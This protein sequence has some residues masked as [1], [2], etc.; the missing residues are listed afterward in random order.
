MIR[1]LVAALATLL[2]AGTA[3]ASG[4]YNLGAGVN[5]PAADVRSV[6]VKTTNGQVETRQEVVPIARDA[7]GNAAGNQHDLAVDGAF[8]GQT[9]AVMQLY[10]EPD[11]DF[12][13]PRAAL[14]EKGFSVY[15]WVNQPPSPTELASKLEKASQLWVISD[16]S[17]THLTA[18]HLEVIK[19]YFDA[20]HGVYIW[21][22]NDPCYGD[23]NLLGKAL[24]GVEMHGNLPGEQRVFVQKD[25]K[26]P[27]VVRNHL[28]STGVETVYE[29]ITVATID[30]NT[31]LTPILY[32]SA[33]NLITAA[34]D[35]DGKRAMFDG[36]FTRL[37]YRWETA[38]TARFVK[39]AAAW[40]ANYERFGKAVTTAAEAKR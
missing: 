24:L 11:F 19:R 5:A 6:E 40:L 32:G 39:N 9:V 18:A 37:Y 12:A 27:G 7:Y 15:R 23:A 21:G 13:Q 3:F 35:K 1:H 2:L 33:G 14:R 34:Y 17:A 8:D 36:G 22:D 4:P 20:G 28:L 30:A 25:G 10:S 16:C 26:G 38:G 31:Q 29:G